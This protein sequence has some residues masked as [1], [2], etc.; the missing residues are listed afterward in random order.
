M[1]IIVG[2]SGHPGRVGGILHAV[3]GA[4]VSGVGNLD[5]EVISATKIDDRQK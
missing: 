2:S 3:R 1:G 5:A 4:G